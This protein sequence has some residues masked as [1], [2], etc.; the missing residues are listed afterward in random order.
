MT[1]KNKQG[2]ESRVVRKIDDPEAQIYVMGLIEKLKRTEDELRA[3]RRSRKELE[4]R[5]NFDA[6]LT[7]LPL[8]RTFHDY[9]ERAL[10]EVR[11]VSAPKQGK[12]NYPNS[13]RAYIAVVK[14]DMGRLDEINNRYGA[15]RGDKALIHT[16]RVSRRSVQ[17]AG[18][19]V[20][21][22]GRKADEFVLFLTGTNERGAVNKCFELQKEMGRYSRVS[23]GLVSSMGI[24]IC[25]PIYEHEVSYR[26]LIGDADHA[27]IAAKWVRKH[28]FDNSR[29]TI[30]VYRPEEGLL[31]Y[32][33]AGS[34]PV[35]V[36]RKNS[37]YALA[38]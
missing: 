27:M 3:E 25:D 23:G 16:A 22:Y 29:G 9:L 18:D 26:A 10:S 11:R 37:G 1:R 4:R 7:G 30:V 6:D 36:Q 8:R 31:L 34:K 38:A 12:S 5:A 24:R 20:A 28:V 13:H 19:F 15:E 33:T 17:R 32:N 2:W 14:L 21:R 35:P